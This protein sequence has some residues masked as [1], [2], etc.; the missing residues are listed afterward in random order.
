MIYDQPA[1]EKSI[2]QGDLIEDCPVV[3][4]RK[5]ASNLRQLDHVD[6]DV[7]RVIVLS[8][9]CD[10]ANDKIID[11][12][13]AEVFDAQFLVDKGVLKPSEIKGQ[14]RAGRVWGWYFCRRTA[15]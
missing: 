5:L 4:I 2:D 8:Q 1:S 11:A 13:V 10:L 7:C 12:N 6:A 3:R 15:S 14:I 9:T